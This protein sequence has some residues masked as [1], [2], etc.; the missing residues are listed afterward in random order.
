VDALTATSG[1]NTISEAITLAGTTSYRIGASGGGTVL[2]VGRIVRTGATTSSL[3]LDPSATLIVSQPIANK[4]GDLTCHSGGTVVLNTASNDI[5]NTAVQYTCTLRLG[6]SDAIATNKI[7]T[8]GGV[9][10]DPNAERGSVNLAGFSQTVSA[11][12]GNGTQAGSYATTRMIINSTPALSTLTVGNVNGSGSFNG[13]IAGNIALTKVGTGTQLLFGVGTNTYSGDTT[14]YAGTLAISNA[15]ALQKSTLNYA[16]G[17]V[18]FSAGLTAFTFGGLAG[19][20]NLGLTNASGVAVALTVGTN[21]SDTIYSGALS[22]SGSLVKVGSGKLTLA[23]V[24]TYTGSTTLSGGT[25]ALGCANALG[26]GTQ[27]ILNGGTLDPGAFANALSSLNIT[28]SGGTLALGSSSGI[29]SFADSSSQTWTGTLNITTS[30]AWVP[31][32]LRFG[33]SASG[34][35]QAQLDSIRVNGQRAWLQ[36]DAQGYLWKMTGTLLRLK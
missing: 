14:V 6:A 3:V 33:T 19:V 28:A 35:T 16:G 15:L 31:A 9:S 36:M 4:G 30:G 7:L 1:S 25:L 10:T 20:Q 24:N 32:S 11:L 23:G 18:S 8:I 27:I 34:L 5:G 12:N 13:V 29:L 2:N 26:S 21:N 17:T 22:G